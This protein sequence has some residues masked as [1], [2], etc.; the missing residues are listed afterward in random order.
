MNS[1]RKGKTGELEAAKAVESALGIEGMRRSQQYCGV[2]GDADIVGIP[3]LHFEVKRYKRISSIDFL[4]QAERDAV[5]ADLPIV[6]MREDGD[7]NWVVQLK[8]DNLK[9]LSQILGKIGKSDG[10]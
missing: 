8:L 3:G 4:R 9:E 6:V 5:N 7:T 10:S 2:A 1:R